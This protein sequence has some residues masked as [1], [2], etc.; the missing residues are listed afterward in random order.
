MKI[1]S[2]NFTCI[3]AFKAPSRA[4]SDWLSVPHA[5][6]VNKIRGTR[7]C[8]LEAMDDSLLLRGCKM[9]SFPSLSSLCDH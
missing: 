3:P 5:C 7:T 6:V 2:G 9:S 4:T 8:V 1:E